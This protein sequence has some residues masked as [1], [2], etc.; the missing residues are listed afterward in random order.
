VVHRWLGHT[1]CCHRDPH[2]RSFLLWLHKCQSQGNTR[3]FYFRLIFLNKQRW[4][5]NRRLCHYPHRR[6]G[7]SIDDLPIQAKSQNRINRGFLCIVSHDLHF[8]REF[9]NLQIANCIDHIH[10]SL[11]RQIELLRS[12]VKLSLWSRILQRHRCRNFRDPLDGMRQQ[13]R[14]NSLTQCL[15]RWIMCCV[16]LHEKF[17]TLT[18]LCWRNM[19]H[20]RLF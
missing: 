6:Q 15:D 12:L 4:A 3:G 9:R 17:S 16:W 11:L 14:N 10:H 5:H 1:F 19:C 20:P 8:W 13:G 7:S 18:L 2:K